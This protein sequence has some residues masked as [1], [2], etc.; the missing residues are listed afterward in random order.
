[1]G[2]KAIL[3]LVMGVAYIL[4]AFNAKTGNNSSA[5]LENYLEYYSRARSHQIAVSGMNIA[6]AK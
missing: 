1:M 4:T 6:A 5:V 3:I 2:G